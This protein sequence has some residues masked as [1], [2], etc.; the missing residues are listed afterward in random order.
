MWWFDRRH[1]LGLA[2][3]AAVSGCGGFRPLH[4]P[5]GPGSALRGQVR[6][7]DPTTPETYFFALEIERAFGP[8]LPGA[9]FD[10]TYGI[11]LGET[12]A[13]RTADGAITRYVLRGTLDWTLLEGAQQRTGG[14]LAEETTWSAASTNV[15]TNAAQDDARRRL[16]RVLAS[17]LATRLTAEAARAAGWP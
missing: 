12:G 3:A 9:R 14:R 15:A 1:F 4:A 8:A 5:D 6:A 13:G 2:A 10:L 16:M 11:T 7:A 17:R